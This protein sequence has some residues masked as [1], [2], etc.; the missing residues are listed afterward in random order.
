M[1]FFLSI[2]HSLNQLLF[3]HLQVVVAEYFPEDTVSCLKLSKNHEQLLVRGD[4]NL[5]VYNTVTER[6]VAHFPRPLDIPREFKLP[7]SHY[8]NINFTQADFSPDDKFVVAAIFRHIYIWNISTNRLLTSLQAPVGIIDHLLIPADRGQIITQQRNSNEINVW[9]LGDAI[10]HVGMLDRL[11]NKIEEI[12]L[13]HDD[14]TAFVRC[15]NSDEIGVL[16][17]NSGQLVDLLT[18]PSPVTSFSLTPNGK[19]ALVASD[20]IRPGTANKIWYMDGRKVIYE[21]GN[22]GAYSVTLQHENCLIAIEQEEKAFKAPYHIKLYTFEGEQFEECRLSY[23]VNFMLV[24]PFVTPADKYLVML[25]A[26]DY[27]EK[28]ALHT[29]PTICAISLK[30]NMAVSTF[31]VKD[32]SETVSMERILSVRPYGNNSYTVIV[33]YTNESDLNDDATKSRKYIHCYGFMIFDVCSGVVCQVIEDLITPQTKLDHLIF[34]RDVSL[35]IDPQSH[36]YNMANGYFLKRLTEQD[37]R[38]RELALG[39]KAVLYAEGQRILVLRLS[40][41]KELANVDVHSDISCIEVCHDERTLILGCSDGS[42]LSYVLGDISQETPDEI[43][44]KIPSRQTAVTQNSSTAAPR[45]WDKVD[46]EFI[47]AYSRPPSAMSIGPSDKHLLKKV[48]PVPRM[49][50]SSETILYA[51]PRSKVCSVM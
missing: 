39:G 46:S 33:F 20:P 13:S 21:F 47:P 49:R 36:I 30:A 38:P 3:I 28:H 40:D 45:S 27:S 8:T 48:K 17:M 26:D 16:D 37:L 14:K 1:I 18:H 43:L 31:S 7:M 11:T 35:C 34:N 15:L 12:K 5:V 9:G 42:I 25:T 24:E 10:G 44:S 4:D 32:L 2:Y 23:E 6:V 29:N 22:V 51:N 41:G 50:P 19:Y